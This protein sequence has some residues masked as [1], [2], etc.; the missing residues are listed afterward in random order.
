[1]QI[2]F[3]VGRAAVYLY[4]LFTDAEVFCDLFVAH[5]VGNMRITSRSRCV[6]CIKRLRKDEEFH[7][8]TT[9]VEVIHTALPMAVNRR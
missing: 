2:Q 6:S 9:V 4:R 7:L 8:R 1:M 5:A 3:A